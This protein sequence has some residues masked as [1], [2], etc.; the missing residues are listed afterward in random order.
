MVTQPIQGLFYNHDWVYAVVGIS[1][2]H[3]R[4]LSHRGRGL[5]FW[6]CL[7]HR[8]LAI[9]Q[10]LSHLERGPLIWQC[11]GYGQ[12]LRLLI[13]QLQFQR[14][15]VFLFFRGIEQVI[16]DAL[17]LFL[18]LLRYERMFPDLKRLHVLYALL[19]GSCDQFRIS[20]IKFDA[21]QPIKIGRL[22]FGRNAQP[23]IIRI[24]FFC[25]VLFAPYFFP[26]PVEMSMYILIL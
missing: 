7:S 1:V 11:L 14:S 21:Q 15:I 4:R 24:E 10:C 8:G 16:S 9:W 12:R 19:G 6:K 2:L 17:N 23:F 18:Y 3:R 20:F 13:P 22:I 5:A 25:H 26:P